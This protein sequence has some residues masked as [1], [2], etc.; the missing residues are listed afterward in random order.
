VISIHVDED[1]SRREICR[2]GRTCHGF[3]EYSGLSRT[4]GPQPLEIAAGA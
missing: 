1:M 4:L 3:L 2:S